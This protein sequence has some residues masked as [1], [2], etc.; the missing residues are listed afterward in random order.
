M[1]VYFVFFFLQEQANVDAEKK[2]FEDWR[3]Q[4]GYMSLSYIIFV[5]EV[6]NISVSYVVINSIKCEYR[7]PLEATEA[8]MKCLIALKT[9]PYLAYYVWIFIHECVYDF[10]SSKS[11]QAIKKF[12]ASFKDYLKS[13]KITV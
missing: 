6:K 4:I 12:I 2:L 7:K 1:I 13:K 11:Y 8:C 3:R 5:G 9:W 10:T